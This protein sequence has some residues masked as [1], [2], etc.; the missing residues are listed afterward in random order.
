[1]EL[2]WPHQH[3]VS[4]QF[5]VEYLK[6]TD[7]L[8]C[9]LKLSNVKLIF[10][11]NCHHKCWKDKFWLFHRKVWSSRSVLASLLWFASTIVGSN[12]ICETVLCDGNFKTWMLTIKSSTPSRP[13]SWLSKPNICRQSEGI[14]QASSYNYHF[15][16]TNT[17]MQG[18][19]SHEYAGGAFRS[20]ESP[21][22]ITL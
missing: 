10:I 12:E 17:F 19:G 8:T 14:K 15:V 6:K 20:N 11:E 13:I 1:M 9:I 7:I 22:S 5:L 18:C 21:F 2:R 16:T 4:A 3:I